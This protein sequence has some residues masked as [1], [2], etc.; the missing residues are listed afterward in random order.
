MNVT[1]DLLDTGERSLLG[2]LT[3]KEIQTRRMKISDLYLDMANVRELALSERIAPVLEQ[4][5]GQSPA[6]CNSLYFEKGSSS[7]RT[8]TRF[9]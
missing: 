5:F 4:L 7:L 3:P 6:L 8:S 2:L 9:I 1:I